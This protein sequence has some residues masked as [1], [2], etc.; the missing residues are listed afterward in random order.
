M[1]DP[2]V[3]DLASFPVDPAVVGAL[4]CLANSD[5]DLMTEAA[6]QRFKQVA[7]RASILRRANPAPS[8]REAIQA[9]YLERTTFVLTVEG[10]RAK[11]RWNARV[12]R[13]TVLFMKGEGNDVRA[14]ALD[15][16]TDGPWSAFLPALQRSKVSADNGAAA[17]ASVSSIA[18]L[19]RFPTIWVMPPTLEALEALL[20]NFFSGVQ[21]SLFDARV[22][23]RNLSD[24]GELIVIRDG[25]FLLDHN[26]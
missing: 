19:S 15:R 6:Q 17:Y 1:T 16:E 14:V 22:V 7:E 12:E 2:N 26:P 5:P 10:P 3:F 11:Q 4:Q 8:L 21:R 23:S 20:P 18:W 9:A 13:Q 25:K 24:S